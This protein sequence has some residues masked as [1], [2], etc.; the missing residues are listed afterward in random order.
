MASDRFQRRIDRFLDQIEEAADQRNWN[1]VAQ[2]SENVLAVD[3]DN[4]GARQCL[5]AANRKIGSAPDHNQT[6]QWSLLIGLYWP[7]VPIIQ[8]RSSTAV[9]G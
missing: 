5:E 9:T 8:P 1:R 6:N 7:L 4:T 3:P 2:L